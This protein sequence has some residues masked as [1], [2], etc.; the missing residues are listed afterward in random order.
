M[1]LSHK[2]FA[3]VDG[4][5][6][7]LANMEQAVAEIREA[8]KRREGFA[9]FTL[10]LDHL[11]K[12]RHDGPFRQAYS[13]ARFVTADGA[14]VAYFASRGG[15][16]VTRTT[17]ADLVEPLANAAAE[18]GLGVYLF[19]TTQD[20]L[21]AAGSYLTAQSKEKLNICG[22]TSPPFGFDPTSPLADEEM[23]RIARSGAHL[24]FVAL[25]PPKGEI[26][27]ARAVS[28]GIRT[29]FICVGAGIDFLAGRQTRAPKLFQTAGIEWVWRLATNPRR[30]VVRYAKCAVLL[31]EIALKT[32]RAS[33]AHE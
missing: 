14:P 1:E 9:A 15:S 20:A 8:A 19:G 26:F 22:S 5:R 4:W 33:S 7:N 28:R 3:E 21:D 16:A 30:F 13:I 25:S 6:I 27:A 11:V 17:G 31:A 32:P 12:L 18:D 29:G 23:D 10:N 24:C 2:Q